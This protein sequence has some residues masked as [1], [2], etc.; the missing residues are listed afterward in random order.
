M[1]DYLSIFK[2]L[3]K[4]KIKYIVVG[5]MAVN[6]HGVPRMTYDIDLLVDLD[7]KNLR[8]FLSLMK[9]WN[10]KPMVPVDIMD[11]VKKSKREDWIKNKNMKAFNLKNPNWAI[12]EI[13]I[14]IDTP[15]D[16]KKAKKNVV[17]YVL[18]NVSIP[19][20]SVKDLIT[21]K[22]TTGRKQDKDDITNLRKAINA[23]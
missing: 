6:F 8:K 4:K 10:F 16:Y 7:N 3:N 15:I 5:G 20:I 17:N 2:E 21:M 14:L 11:F 1:L 12:S 23:E 9:E 18:E 19:T 22:K 13:D